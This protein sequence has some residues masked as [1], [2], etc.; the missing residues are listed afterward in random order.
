MTDIYMSDYFRR[1]VSEKAAE[2]VE[3][4]V[5]AW[6]EI[7]PIKDATIMYVYGPDSSCGTSKLY[8]PNTLYLD[9]TDVK[10]MAAVNALYD[11]TAYIL[12]GRS[13]GEARRPAPKHPQP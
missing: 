12:D 13:P 1:S 3:K 5:K 9:F 6:L 10:D 7:N 2:I 8:T 4:V 11:F